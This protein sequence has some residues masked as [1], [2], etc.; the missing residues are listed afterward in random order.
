MPLVYLRHPLHGE[1]VETNDMIAQIDKGNGWVEFDPSVKPAP[2]EAVIEP[3][4]DPV[5]VPDFL[6]APVKVKRSKL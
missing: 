2:V 6:S 3:A 4:A 1:K 5:E